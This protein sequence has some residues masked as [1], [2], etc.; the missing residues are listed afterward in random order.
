[1]AATTVRVSSPSYQAYQ[2]LHVAFDDHCAARW[3]SVRPM[4]LCHVL[5]ASRPLLHCGLR[6]YEKKR[7]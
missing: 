5:A 3:L 6:M 2:I 4:V 7:G 1:M